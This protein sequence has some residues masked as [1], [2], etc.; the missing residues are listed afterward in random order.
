[1]K[2]T[3]LALICIMFTLFS[4]CTTINNSD[5]VGTYKDNNPLGTSTLVLKSDGTSSQVLI[6]SAGKRYAASGKWKFVSSDNR[7]DIDNGLS[8]DDLEFSGKPK[9]ERVGMSYSVEKS[10]PKG[11]PQIVVDSD[12]GIAFKKIK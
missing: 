10:F 12:K 11:Q 5:I 8:Y 2:K 6:T 3:A 4:G 7:I 1:M 9:V